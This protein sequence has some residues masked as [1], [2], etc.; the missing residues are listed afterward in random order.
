VELIDEK[1]K[2]KIYKINL[3]NIKEYNEFKCPSK[4]VLVY[5][6]Q[7]RTVRNMLK[8]IDSIICPYDDK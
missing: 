8:N 2:F 6:F 4:R 5:I 7:G 3:K 1:D